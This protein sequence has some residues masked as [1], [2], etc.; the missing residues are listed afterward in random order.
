MNDTLTGSQQTME[1]HAP[2]RKKGCG[3]LLNALI[4]IAVFL[5]AILV[6]VWLL[7]MHSSAPL[8]TVAGMIESAGSQQNLRITGISGSLSSGLS[9]KKMKWDDGEISDMRFR[10]SGIMDVIRRKQLI[11]HEMHVGSATLDTTFFTDSPEET[12]TKSTDDASPKGESTDP[13]LR[14]LQIDRVSLNQIIIK[15]P[16]TG[17]TIIIPK[18]E[19]TGFKVEKGAELELGNLDAHSDHLV[20][21][22]S[23][24]PDSDYQKRL[25]ITLM[26]K[27][28]ARIL[29][30]VRI[31]A[32]LGERHGKAHF[33][34]KVLDGTVTFAAGADG[35]QHIRAEGANLA[36]F[37]DAPLP[38]KLF[39]DAGISNPETTG[40]TLTVR[41]G[42]FLLGTKTF[43][44]QPTTVSGSE[45][46][47]EGTVFLA[48]CREGVS[49]IRYEIPFIETKEQ[50]QS[51]TPRLT[52]TPAMSPEDIM[53][54]LF[55]GAAF[56][57][58]PPQDQEKIRS[59]MS[60]FSF[61]SLK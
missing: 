33:D 27:L 8:R 11:I 51:F 2:P 54:M 37:I 58:L 50:A 7:I 36:D 48:L 45:E 34:I 20:I 38:N 40:S 25:E 24:P 23:N 14:L 55:H 30:P 31:D 13:P 28:D 16:S 21:K 60:W 18:I 52:S 47:P 26:P 41:S 9:F 6:A 32:H 17:S 59:R 29:K 44:I 56:S 35:N 46:K 12:E 42:S 3:C 61:P 10:Y 4:G 15:N 43:A 5:T 57:A 19:W 1:R 49:E 39:L 53:A 22:T